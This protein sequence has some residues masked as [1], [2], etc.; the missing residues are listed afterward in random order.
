MSLCERPRRAGI[1]FKVTPIECFGFYGMEV[2]P[3]TADFVQ[4]YDRN[5]AR[6]PLPGANSLALASCAIG[7]FAT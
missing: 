2:S 5:S 1:T 4:P 7:K 3:Y 6:I